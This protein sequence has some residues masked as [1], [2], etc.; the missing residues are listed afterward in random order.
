MEFFFASVGI[1]GGIRSWKNYLNAPYER[2]EVI[3]SASVEPKLVVA[4]D[5]TL[6]SCP[7]QPTFMQLLDYHGNLQT[8]HQF[9]TRN[10]LRTVFGFFWSPLRTYYKRELYTMSD[11]GTVAL[12]WVVD[13]PNGS[14][15]HSNNDRPIILLLHG[16]LGDSQSEYIYFFA[17]QLY[18][19]GFLPAVFV[20]RGCGDLKLTSA[21]FFTGRVSSDLFELIQYLRTH[22][23]NQHLSTPR[24]L[25]LI[26]YSLGGASV[27]HYLGHVK[28]HD[29][30]EHI[31]AAMSVCPPWNCGSNT[32]KPSRI[33]SFWLS[34]INIP[35]KLHF[36]QHYET[37]L[38]LAPEIYREVEVMKV[39]ATKT[40]SAFDELLCH[41]Y[42]QNSFLTTTETNTSGN[43]STTVTTTTATSEKIVKSPT[44]SEKRGSYKHVKEYYADISPIYFA[45]HIHSIPTLVLTA[46][47]DPVCRHSDVL[48]AEELGKSVVV[49][50][51]RL[52]GH[53]SYPIRESW[54]NA[55]SDKLAIAW[56]RQFC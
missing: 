42:H 12:D 51:S 17:K 33:Y 24:K 34:L 39:L 4:I 16:L 20:A 43:S 22:E 55:W 5:S 31:T 3:H 9:I 54:T 48:P 2:M 53:L 38:K 13:A 41:T 45:P 46:E 44:T 56:F 50:K 23:T 49:V 25:F 40:I 1:W 35:L 26:G 32:I 29:V 8:A 27:L 30:N 7:Y 21:S 14:I 15:S 47:D 19:Q 36:A 6:G 52:G 37:L 11:G 10:I 18:A 28:D